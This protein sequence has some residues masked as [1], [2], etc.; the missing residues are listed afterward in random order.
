MKLNFSG[1]IIQVHKTEADWIQF[2][3]NNPNYV[4]ASGEIIVYDPDDKNTETRFK[5]GDGVRSVTDLPFFSQVQVITWG[6]DD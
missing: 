4:P 2:A 6:E 1:Q 5:I 3:E